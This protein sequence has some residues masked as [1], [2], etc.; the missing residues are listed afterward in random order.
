MLFR[1][2]SQSRYSRA[3]NIYST[4]FGNGCLNIVAALGA[5]VIGQSNNVGT[6][7]SYSMVLGHANT[8]NS[9]LSTIFGEECVSNGR[10]STL[11]GYGLKSD[12]NYQF[13]IGQY[14]DNS[15]EHIFEI[16]FGQSDTQRSNLLCVDYDGDLHCKGDI[17]CKKSVSTADVSNGVSNPGS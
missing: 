10:Y 5:Y 6:S 1:S 3:N 9:Y 2:V 14:N 17:Y 11:V 12:A 15:N 8:A 4:I 16:G 7:A 13:V